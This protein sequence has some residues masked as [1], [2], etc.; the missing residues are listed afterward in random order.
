MPS[1]LGLTRDDD[2]GLVRIHHGMHSISQAELGE[3]VAD[4]RLGRRLAHD[5]AP[6]DLRVGAT[7]CDLEEHLALAGCE[8]REVGGL[9]MRSRRKRGEA[10][11]HA[12]CHGGGE[13]R[14]SL[15]LFSVVLA[16]GAALVALETRSAGRSRAAT[17][18]LVVAAVTVVLSVLVAIAS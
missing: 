6:G 7:A 4:V 2:T 10:L 18:A 17:A 16:G 3:Y 5:Q 14:V 11:D 9:C 8:S 15:G 1:L 13:Q 12:S